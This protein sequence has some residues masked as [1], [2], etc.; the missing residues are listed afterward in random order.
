MLRLFRIRARVFSAVLVAGF[1]AFWLGSVASTCLAAVD[2]A[3]GVPNTDCG[4]SQMA[5]AVAL[6]EQAVVSCPHLQFKGPI[7]CSFDFSSAPAVVAASSRSV[8][9]RETGGERPEDWRSH[10]PLHTPL[11]LTYLSLLN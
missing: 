9:V 7:T 2:P 8:A 6:C 4:K 1:A 3:C 10:R 11:Y 5:S